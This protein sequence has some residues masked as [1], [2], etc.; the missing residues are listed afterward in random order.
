LSTSV[1]L[2]VLLAAITH[3]SWNAWLKVSGDRLIAL[4][5]LA[6][7][8][9]LVGLLSLPFVGFPSTEAWP[10]LLASIIIHI[11]YSLML[12]RAYEFADLSTTYPIARGVAPLVVAILSGILLEEPLGIFG[13]FAVSL[14]VLGV[15]W[16]GL[17]SRSNG[18]KGLTIS[19]ITGCLIGI[20][21]FLDGLGG[22]VSGS[23]SAY[24]ACLLIGTAIPLFI[25][26]A[27][28]H[29]RN[30]FRLVRPLL[31]R[32][33]LAGVLSA[34]AFAVVIWAMSIAP[35]GLVAAV[36]ESSVVFVSMLGALLLKERVRWAAVILVFSGIML[37]R[38]A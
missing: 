28:V 27:V 19:L 13:L 7:G 24:T 4:A 11:S 6:I 17:P 8:W 2:L 20:Y 33:F 25:V 22:R 35:M 9:L 23:P 12:I 29:K 38:M 36:R 31:L 10:F 26:T 16:L 34:I 3:A 18:Y 21:T 15:I 32:G 5:T 37:V 1:L 14:I 30:C